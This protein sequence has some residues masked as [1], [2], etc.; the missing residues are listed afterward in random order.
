MHPALQCLAIY[1]RI[2]QDLVLAVQARKFIYHHLE[3]TWGVAVEMTAR[4]TTLAEEPSER[5]RI[6]DALWLDV[7]PVTQGWVQPPHF[8]QGYILAMPL[9]PS[10]V[11]F[12]ERGLRIVAPLIAERRPG[13]QLVIR[14]EKI[15]YILT[16]FQDEGLEAAIIGWAAEEFGFEPL[17]VQAR[18]DRTLRR[19][20][21]QFPEEPSTPA[22]GS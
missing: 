9:P 4:T 21:F 10:Q 18:F 6:T 20:V 14:V 1:E 13:E 19:Y 7:W 15:E 16:D 3:T 2:V 22:G 17:P 5:I 12:L 8:S 11:P